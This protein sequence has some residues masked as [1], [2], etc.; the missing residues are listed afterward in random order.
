MQLLIH[1]EYSIKNN[2]MLQSRFED[3]KGGYHLD[4]QAELEASIMRGYII[5]LMRTLSQKST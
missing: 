5:D 1:L 3:E 4:R 2:M